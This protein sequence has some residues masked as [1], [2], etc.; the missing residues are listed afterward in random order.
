VETANARY[1]V[2][3]SVD[4]VAG[5]DAAADVGVVADVDAGADVDVDVDA[6]ESELWLCRK[7][8]SSSN[9][10]PAE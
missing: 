2:A 4:A 8:C 6:V 5:V 9:P 10:A 3:S 7:A 1:A